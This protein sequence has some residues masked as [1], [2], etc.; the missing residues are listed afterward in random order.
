MLTP[1]VENILVTSIV[2]TLETDV[3]SSVELTL[4][5]L[6]ISAWI[7]TGESFLSM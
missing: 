6:L 5:R 7:A 3:V 4:V 2:T 1:N